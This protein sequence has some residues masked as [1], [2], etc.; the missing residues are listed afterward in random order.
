M[1]IPDKHT[2]IK[3]SVVYISGIMMNEVKANGIIRYIDLHNFIITKIGIQAKEVFELS[4]SFL[5]L[6]GKIQY[7]EKLDSI[8]IIEE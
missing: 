7:N 4:I 6:I 2:N 1:L 3:Y 5:F 8:L